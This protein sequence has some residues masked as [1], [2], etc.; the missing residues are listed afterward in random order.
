MA[1]HRKSQGKTFQQRQSERAQS[2]ARERDLV[3]DMASAYTCSDAIAHDFAEQCDLRIEDL[4]F[5][6][7]C[8]QLALDFWATPPAPAQPVADLLLELAEERRRHQAALTNLR[9]RLLDSTTSD[10]DHI[11]LELPKDHYRQLIRDRLFP[12]S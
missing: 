4:T 7:L 6:L 9:Q 10:A 2:A 8:S 11:H 5:D 12:D 3:D 1:H